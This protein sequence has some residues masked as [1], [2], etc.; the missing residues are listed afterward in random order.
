M[1]SDILQVKHSLYLQGLIVSRSLTVTYDS[2]IGDQ[3]RGLITFE[4]DFRKGFLGF[5]LP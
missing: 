2:H 1:I 3:K 4:P 5:I